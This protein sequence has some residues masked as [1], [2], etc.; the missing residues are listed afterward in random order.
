[1]KYRF[2]VLL[3]LAA[4]MVFAGSVTALA[5]IVY[6]VSS[7]DTLWSLA[8]RFD[9]TMGA[10]E[11]ANGLSGKQ[12]NVGSVLIIPTASEQGRSTA[13]TSPPAVNGGTETGTRE[14]AAVRPLVYTVKAGDSLIHLS[15]LSGVSVDDIKRLNGLGADQINIGQKLV[16]PTA[17]SD[18]NYVDTYVVR[19]GDT[20]ASIASL[21]STTVWELKRLNKR[22]GVLI[23]QGAS[24]T[25]PAPRGP[26][27]RG[28]LVKRHVRHTVR[29]GETLYSISLRHGVSVDEIRLENGIKG[30]RIVVG[31]ALRIPSEF[32]VPLLG[33][34]PLTGPDNE[35]ARRKLV[36]TAKSYLGSPYRFGGTSVKRGIDCSA[37]VGK[38]FRHYDVKLPRTARSIYK[39]GKPVGKNE[40][41]VADLVFFRTYAS[42]PSHVGIYIGDGKI[43]HASSKAKRVIISRID[44]GYLRKRYIGA[45][46][47]PLDYKL[48]SAGR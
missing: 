47:I 17:G 10:I 40:L 48:A 1:M 46:R 45:K 20:L 25:V 36:Q 14:G 35:T 21:H 18:I 4:L 37:F 41:R 31:Q 22:Q 11:A 43:I 9:T 3:S 2:P 28:G 13:H 38:V 8:R 16:L 29:P 34:G 5:D 27:S 33:V 12:I 42:F 15:R 39:K 30:T 19:E 23:R 7:G 24:L 44:K 26:G 6:T 32:G